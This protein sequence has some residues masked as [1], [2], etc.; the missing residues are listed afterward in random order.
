MNYKIHECRNVRGFW[1]IMCR[2]WYPGFFNLSRFGIGRLQ[3]DIF[4]YDAQ[5]TLGGV[6]V[7]EGD[8]VLRIHIPSGGPLTKELRDD[9][10]R[11]A[12]DFFKKYAKNGVLFYLCTSWLLSNLH[13]GLLSESSNIRSFMNDFD[14]QEGYVVENNGI[15][16]RIWGADASLP[17]NELPEKSS[18]MRAYKKLLLDG[19][20]LIW[21][22]GIFAFDGENY[23]R[24]DG[25]HPTL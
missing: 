2:D 8:T 10:Y 7:N 11:R 6:T 14:L 19:Q 15:L 20:K 12:Y 24:S 17:V 1:E 4:P 13:I 9:S 22:R 23:I 25:L 5:Y 16:Q 3:Y 21:G 18:L